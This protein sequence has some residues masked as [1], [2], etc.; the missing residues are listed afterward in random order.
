MPSDKSKSNLNLRLSFDFEDKQKIDE[1]EERLHNLG[2]IILGRSKRGLD[3]EGPK[4]RL[5]DALEVVITEENGNVHVK[6]S[7]DLDSK[8]TKN[9]PHIYVPRRPTLF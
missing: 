7:V 5:Q 2:I 4:E 1:L 9:H 3:I 8:E 6:N